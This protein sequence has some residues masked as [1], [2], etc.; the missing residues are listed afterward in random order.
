MKIIPD[1][2]DLEIFEKG[3]GLI[4][5]KVPWMVASVLNKQAKEMTNVFIPQSLNTNFMIRDKRFMKKQLW[6]NF[7]KKNKDPSTNFSE[8][9]SLATDRF[10]GWEEQQTGSPPKKK[11]TA[12]TD[13][14][15]G[16]SFAKKQRPVTRMKKNT[17]RRQS[18]YKGRSKKHRFFNMIRET[19]ANRLN[20]IISKD[21]GNIFNLPAGLY[22]WRGR[23]LRML[24]SFKRPNAAPA[25]WMND[26]LALLIKHRGGFDAEFARTLDFTIKQSFKGLL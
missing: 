25:D 16:G 17:F 3:M 19:Q 1:F 26:A 18:Q 8:A 4:P 24:Q 23:R 15:R 13:T 2:S 14:A 10:T 6:T 21:L 5:K 7:A 9:G 11:R 22:G 12:V 20:F